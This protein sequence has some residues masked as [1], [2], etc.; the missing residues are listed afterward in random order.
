VRELTVRTGESGN[1]CAF[2][3]DEDD[4]S[5]AYSTRWTALKAA[6]KA[7]NTAAVQMKRQKQAVPAQCWSKSLFFSLMLLAL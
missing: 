3:E 1:S 4:E 2:D 7:A 5:E 6:A